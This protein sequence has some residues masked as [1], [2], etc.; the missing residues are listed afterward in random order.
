MELYYFTPSSKCSALMILSFK[1]FRN[2]ALFL[3]SV[4]ELFL[5]VL[6]CLQSLKQWRVTAVY[7]P[8][9][10]RGKEKQSNI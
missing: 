10:T 5:R 1:I 8:V 6:K 4:L 3:A 2:T 7:Q 9:G